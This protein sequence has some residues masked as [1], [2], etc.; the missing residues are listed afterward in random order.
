MKFANLSEM[1][2]LTWVDFLTVI[3]NF[4]G[5]FSSFRFLFIALDFL[6]RKEKAEAEGTNNSINKFAICKKIANASSKPSHLLLR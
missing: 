1:K 4:N 3:I 6:F 5:T 2:S